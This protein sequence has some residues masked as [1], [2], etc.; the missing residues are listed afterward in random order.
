MCSFVLTNLSLKVL[1]FDILIQNI[2]RHGTL[3]GK[4]IGSN[5]RSVLNKRAVSSNGNTRERIHALKPNGGK[6]IAVT[7]RL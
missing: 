5:K 4:C 3:F 2:I 7:D 6:N 1:Q